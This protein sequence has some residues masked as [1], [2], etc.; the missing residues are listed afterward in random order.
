MY[1]VHCAVDCTASIA[2]GLISFDIDASLIYIGGG[3]DSVDKYTQIPMHVSI[4]HFT[5]VSKKSSSRH[6]LIVI[7]PRTTGKSEIDAQPPSDQDL[8]SL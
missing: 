8:E 2:G 3:L 5:V 7:E 6:Q 4:W 1:V